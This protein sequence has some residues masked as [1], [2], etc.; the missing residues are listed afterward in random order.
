MENIFLYVT[1]MTWF[2]NWE[3]WDLSAM[4]QSHQFFHWL[5]GNRMKY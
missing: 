1:F 5:P 3:D 4:V 2:W